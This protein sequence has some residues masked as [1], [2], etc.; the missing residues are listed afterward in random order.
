MKKTLIALLLGTAACSSTKTD[1]APNP[2]TVSW[3][4]DNRAI[5]VDHWVS[6]S[7]NPGSVITVYGREYVN[8][9]IV[10]EVQFELPSTA[11]TYSLGTT[12]TAWAT[13]SKGGVKYFAGNAPGAS[14]QLGSGTLVLTTLTGN[15]AAGT[16]TFTGIDPVTNSP[17]TVSGGKF[18]VPI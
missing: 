12:S 8:G 3:Q 18:Q 15:Q 4:V 5:T 14:G 2:H 1:P 9:V 7:T 11:G 17:K 16:F 10:S 6:G 13:Y